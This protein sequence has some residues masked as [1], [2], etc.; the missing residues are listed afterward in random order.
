MGP[1]IWPIRSWNCLAEY[2]KGFK[3][4][5]QP[6]YRSTE[7]PVNKGVSNRV[8][9]KMQQQLFTETKGKYAETLSEKL[10]KEQGLISKNEAMFNIH[11]PQSQEL[12]AKARHRLKFE[13]LF[14]IQ[15]QLVVK[16]SDQ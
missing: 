9:Q 7:A 5:M 14:F 13:E 2:K 10:I 8:M 4:S 16:K 1:L 3:I 15:L 12:L 11:F 6:V